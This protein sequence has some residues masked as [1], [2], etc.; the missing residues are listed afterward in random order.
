MMKLSINIK[1]LLLLLTVTGSYNSFADLSLEGHYQGKNLF[2]QNPEDEDGF[3][4]C[5]TNVTV[6]GDPMSDGVESSAFEIPFEEFGIKIGD[7]VFIV[8]EH[9]MGC[10]PKILNSEVLLPKSTYEIQNISCTPD[11]K[12]EWSTTG[13]SGKLA[14]VI[15]QY[16][17]NKWVVVGEVDGKGTSGP[18]KYTFEVSPHSGENKIRVAQTDHTGKKRPSKAVTFVNTSIKEP[19]FNPKRVKKIIKFTASGKPIETKYEIFDAYG[20]I[21]KK[22][23]GS[24]VDC[25]NLK[26]GAYYINYDNKN[27]K[28]IKA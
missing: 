3:G 28:F 18:N 27:E 22:G 24:Q 7:P 4:F 2:V 14:F 15:E 25:S 23:V 10:K 5:V 26:K 20:N 8:L 16:R 1:L 9:G 6:N 19:E 17:W 13:E 11:G 21:V 12:L